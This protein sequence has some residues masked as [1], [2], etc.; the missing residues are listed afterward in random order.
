MVNDTGADHMVETLAECRDLL[1]RQP[2]QLDVGERVSLDEPS[3]GLDAGL[4]DIDADDTRARVAEPV[5]GRLERATT[6][7]EDRVV[8][9]KRCGR[10]ESGMLDPTARSVGPRFDLAVE[11]VDGRWVRVRVVERRDLVVWPAHES[12]KTVAQSSRMLATTQS[13]RAAVSRIV[14]VASNVPA[15]PA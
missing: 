3:C 7:D 12:T 14:S 5:A 1:D 9:P 4:A 2:V 10:P 15:T 8:V 6:G 11:V 13:S